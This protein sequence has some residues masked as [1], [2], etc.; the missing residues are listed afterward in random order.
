MKLNV[1]NL[2]DN[3][4]KFNKYAI[5]SYPINTQDHKQLDFFSCNRIFEN[6]QSCLIFEN[7]PTGA[8]K[9]F[10]ILLKK[11]RKGVIITRNHPDK[12]NNIVTSNKI[13][14][15]WLSTEDYDYCI[16]PWDINLMIDTIKNFIDQDN[17][18][19][20][21]L[22]GL[23]YLSTYNDSNIILNVI[24]RIAGIVAN[25]NAK[26]LITIDPIAIGNQFLTKI[27]KESEL[28]IIPSSPIKEVLKWPKTENLKMRYSRYT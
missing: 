27:E 26:F 7:K 9:I 4:K 16:N 18:G 23:E 1:I 12:I 28:L 19:I 14:M 22:N 10:D 5:N 15:Y 3:F 6:T 13:D 21:L 2:I 8:I 17:H 24:F 11:G 25:T 20:I